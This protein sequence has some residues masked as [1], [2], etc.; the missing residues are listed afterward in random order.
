M[1]GAQTAY[2][3]QRRDRSGSRSRPFRGDVTS[4]SG[5]ANSRDSDFQSSHQNLQLESEES[6]T[7]AKTDVHP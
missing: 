5:L 2:G 6:S 3:P 7:L 1:R 4:N